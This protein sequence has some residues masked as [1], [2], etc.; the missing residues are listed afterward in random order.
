MLLYEI[1]NVVRPCNLR[2]TAAVQH[3]DVVV[4]HPL[5]VPLREWNVRV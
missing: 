2:A 3:E 4:V 5:N 1:W